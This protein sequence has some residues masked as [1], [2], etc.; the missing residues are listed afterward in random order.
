MKLSN[1]AW[2]TV[3]LMTL[4]ACGGGGGGGSSAS[5]PVVTNTAPTITDPG[6]LSLLE[7]STSVASLSASD[8]QNNSLSFSIASGED[9]DLFSITTGGVLSFSSAPDFEARADADEDNV[10]EVTVQ[11]SDGSLTDTQALTITVT[12]AFEGRV[13][14]APIAGATVFV[15]LNGNDEQDAD[16]PS[17][18][19]DDSG[20]FNVDT[21]T[22]P[23]GSSAKVISKGGT[24]TKTGKALPDLALISDVPADI[25]KPANVTPLTTVV[26]SVD[27]PEEKAQVLQAMGI[28]K[29]PEEL[30]T[31]DNWAAAETG[32]ETA[33]AAQRVNQQVGLLLQT[34]ATVADDGDES[35]DISVSLAKQVATEISE[36]AVSDEGI[37]LTSSDTLT[38]VLSEA[39]AE[40]EPTLAVEAAAIAAVAS[41]VATVNAV[42]ADPTLDP[43]SDV[44]ADIVESAQEELQ[45]SVADVVSGEV[46]VEAF[47]EATDTTEL[48]AGVVVA[49]DALDTDEDGVP[50]A[51]DMDDDGDGV[52]DG[53]DAF[54]KDN[55]EWL[56]SD[57]D[58]IGDNSDP[59]PNPD[60]VDNSSTTA[61]VE[62]VINPCASYVNEGGQTLKGEFDSPNCSYPVSFADAGNNVTTDLTIPALE[63]GGA[64]M[65]DGSLFIG[66]AHSNDA[67]LTAAGIAEGG[68]GPQLTIEAGATLA[69]IGA[70]FVTI[71]R[72]STLF[73]V[74]TAAKPITFT[75]FYDVNGTAA[76]NAVEQWGGMVIN[77]F[78]VSNKCSYTGTRG[79]AGF[80]KDGECNIPAEGAEG[81]D[82]SYYGGDNDADSSGRMEYVVV[83]HTGGEVGIGWL[84][85]ITFGGVGSNTI[86]KNLQSYS[87]Y[88]D[89]IEMFGG[90]VN[91]ENFAAVYVRDDSIDID[92]GYIGTITNAL[93][94][95][96]SDDGNHCIEADGIGSY[97]SKTNAQIDDFIARGLNSAP[98]IKNL[99]CIISPNATGTHDPGAGWR[100][101]E[102]IEPTI[103]DSL[104]ISSFIADA[105]AA[106]TDG[107]Y[108]FRPQSYGTSVTADGVIM[109]CQDNFKDDGATVAAANDMQFATL[110]AGVATDPTATADTGLVIVEGAKK[111]S[112]VALATALVDD[113]APTITAAG[114]GATYIGAITDGVTNPYDGWTVGIFEAD[115]EPLWFE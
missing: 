108:C 63:D 6:A 115:A 47:E 44:A 102:G 32:D 96:A 77:G 48:F 38:T 84:N 101:R 72:G 58:G 94:I 27:T 30:L 34:A 62:T 91:F 31:T 65:F 7:G 1:F 28:D 15:D 54:S 71:N 93:V 14:D 9:E 109:A 64:H 23:E 18:V 89:G 61:P 43:L 4:A 52:A 85:A 78:G 60:S 17:G 98:T 112:S 22:V 105:D 56:D 19:T 59:T 104:V 16:E 53:A 37:D 92:E 74:G 82:E 66:E 83:K 26:A 57:G 87:T 46:S 113:A 110:T 97:S 49:A 10:Y 20:F 100:L 70:R 80:A 86:V 25:T 55:T 11:V 88:D 106:D 90:A 99:T 12:D 29:T 69:F 35:T 2:S 41:S 36:I 76:Y 103:H 68:D 45:T 24:D 73:A 95:Q 13:V 40:V 114:T 79:E 8:A 21:F 111:L 51:L 75:S 42:V 50:D 33:K 3:A 67:E 81:L 107:N 5:T 39:V